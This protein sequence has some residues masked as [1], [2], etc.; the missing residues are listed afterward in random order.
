MLFAI[1]AVEKSAVA[2]LDRPPPSDLLNR[3]RG[4]TVEEKDDTS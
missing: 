1:A 2:R 3:M 4:A